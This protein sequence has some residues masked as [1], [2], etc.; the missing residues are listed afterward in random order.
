M[1]IGFCILESHRNPRCS[2][3]ARFLIPL[4][5]LHGLFGGETVYTRK[6]CFLLSDTRHK[7][8]P[9]RI[10]RFVLDFRARQGRL[11]QHRLHVPVDEQLVSVSVDE[12]RRR[13]HHLRALQSVR[14]ER[15]RH[16]RMVAADG[17]VRSAAGGVRR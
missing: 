6:C 17:S 3:R 11:P 14:D 15:G 10:I 1:G 8:F 2:I 12:L 5:R 7:S 16:V 4:R 13:R 9:L